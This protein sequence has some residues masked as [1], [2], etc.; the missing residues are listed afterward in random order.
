MGDRKVGEDANYEKRLRGHMETLKS[1]LK[2]IL[3]RLL[4]LAL[5]LSA[6]ASCGPPAGYQG[7][8]FVSFS[9][10]KIETYQFALFTSPEWTSGKPF[11]SAYTVLVKKDGSY[12]IHKH[13]QMDS[14]KLSWTKQ[15]L[16]Y[17]DRYADYWLT[18][19]AKPHRRSV[20]KPNVEDGL[21]TLADGSTRVGIYNGGFTGQGRDYDERI[22]ISARDRSP[23]FRS[24]RQYG[25]TFACGN[26]VYN[27]SDGKNPDGRGYNQL[28]RTVRNKRFS[29]SPILVRQAPLSEAGSP[30]T[31]ASCSG[32]EAVFLG[33]YSILSEVKPLGGKESESLLAV[34]RKDETGVEIAQTMEVI[35]LLHRRWRSLPLLNPDKTAFASPYAKFIYSHQVPLSLRGRF[36][37]W[38]HGD[39]RL[40][41]TD[42][43]TGITTIVNADLYEGIRR[44]NSSQ[45]H[46]AFSDDQ[47]A[48]LEEDADSPRRDLTIHVIDLKT[49]RMEKTLLLHGLGEKLDSAM[50]VSDFAVRP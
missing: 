1:R 38:L 2:G 37:Y 21:A 44:K 41:K 30:V 29:L 39:G 23:S 24:H 34:K 49:G 5:I 15:G 18:D 45:Y 22:T 42:I 8:P 32:D 16:F 4:P 20:P 12:I 28:D 47:A 13:A 27:I 6:S 36:L 19:Q 10:I 11:P 31:N 40:L 9:S 14:G 35:D 33:F 25:T 3:R 43:R 17:S 7:K 48:I 46:L 50:V 26:D